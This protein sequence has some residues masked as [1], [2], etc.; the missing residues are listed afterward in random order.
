MD[1]HIGR[2]TEER[3]ILVMLA[4]G[5]FRFKPGEYKIEGLDL[6]EKCDVTEDG[7]VW[8]FKLK[9]GVMFHPFPGYP[10]GVELSAEDVVYSIKRAGDPK[11]SAF[12]SDMKAFS[13][14]ALDDYTVKIT[15]KHRLPPGQMERTLSNYGGGF[16]VSKKAVEKLG[17]DFATHPIGTGPFKIEKF[18]PG[19]KVVLGA[20]KKYFRGAPKLEGIEVIF[21]PDLSSREAAIRSGEVDMILGFREQSWVEKVEK[22]KN[23]DI[24]PVTHGPGAAYTLHFDITKPP[25]DDIKVRKAFAYAINRE[26]VVAFMGEAMVDPEYAAIPHEL[27]GSL[28][29]EEVEAAGL[30]YQYDLEKAKQLLADA[31]H[32]DLNIKMFISQKAQ[33]SRALENIQAQ[34]MKAAI[35]LQLTVVDHS[36]YHSYIRNDVNPIV[37]YAAARPTPDTWFS[38]FY[39]SS[40]IVVKGKTPVTN[41][42]HCA[43]IDDLIEKARSAGNMSDAITYWKEAQIKILEDLYSYSLY[44]QKYAF[45]VNKGLDWGYDLKASHASAPQITENTDINRQ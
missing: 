19:V 10:D 1:P 31:G 42:S 3:F 5:L 9:K 24:V 29:K 14:E 8:T 15:L 7:K 44:G 12:A 36:T 16:V 32:K 21:M 45:A 11:S 41:F 22:W 20:H 27:P 35:N 40:S 34:L 25:F 26:E 13:P 33:Y 28:S 30:L 18:E 17:K 43:S 38:Q 37:V 39:H 4:N 23:K 6:A 2:T